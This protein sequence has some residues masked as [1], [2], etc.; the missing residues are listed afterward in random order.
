MFQEQGAQLALRK[1]FFVPSFEVYH[2]EN[3][4][5]LVANPTPT[6]LI[7]FDLVKTDQEGHFKRVTIDLSEEGKIRD[8]DDY[9]M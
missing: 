6:K 2:G 1:H 4:F 7:F 8:Y 9:V 5:V 3:T